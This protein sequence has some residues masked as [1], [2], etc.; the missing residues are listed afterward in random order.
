MDE[1]FEGEEIRYSK[2]LNRLGTYEGY[3]CEECKNCGRQ[4][5]EMYSNG[6]RICEKCG[7]DQDEDDYDYEYCEFFDV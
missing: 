1:F 4:R 2:F 5:V 3:D 6:S 7:Y